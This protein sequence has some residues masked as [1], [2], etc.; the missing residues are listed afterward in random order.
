LNDLQPRLLVVPHRAAEDARSAAAPIVGIVDL[1]TVRDSVPR[2]LLGEKEL[3]P[4]G[5][6]E[7]GTADDIALL[8]HT[9]GT[10]SRPKQVPLLQRNVI[11]ATRTV[12][13]HYRL[14]AD[15]VSY[16]PM[17]LF[18][19]HGLVASTFAA[20]FA[21]GSVVI[22]RRVAPRRFW[23][24][25]RDAG[26]T[27]FSAGPTIH[28]MLLEQRDAE[29]PSSALRFVRSCSSALSPALMTR[30]EDVYGVPCSRPTE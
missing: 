4:H 25:A 16:C 9:S 28:Q 7:P 13:H 10:T 3:V 26:V 19:I 17:P 24:Q 22:P 14:E 5:S 21:G 27:W 1:V 11:A 8:L 15:D 30:A 23:K 18:H 29:G 6:F 2:L 20:L 12:A